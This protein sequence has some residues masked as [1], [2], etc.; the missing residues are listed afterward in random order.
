VDFNVA[1]GENGFIMELWGKAPAVFTVGLIS[2]GG[3]NV[4]RIQLKLGEFRSIRFFPE[5]TILEI[6][7]FPGETISGDQVIRMNFRRPAPGTWRLRVYASGSG[8]LS[9][10]SGVSLDFD[11]WLPISN[12]LK[13]DTFFLNASP[14][15]TITSPG[16]SAYSITYVPYDISNDSLYVRA[17]R[18]Y[19][20]DGRIKPDLAA[21]G[22][23]VSIPAP[24][25]DGRPVT[26]SGSSVAAAFGAGMGA[27]MQEW[28]IVKGNDLFLNGQSM[29]FHLIQGATRPGAYE[30]PN[31]EWGYGIVNIYDAFLS[32]RR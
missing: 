1:E 22:V 28:A 12:F 3:E 10:A 9:S 30:Y 25:P 27:L 11:L 13:E 32:F 2:P 4:D 31:R 15:E 24:G 26:R 18:G 23:A 16:T 5:E 8:N 20:R 14:N 21:P 29:R 17:S 19:T 6:R 7:S